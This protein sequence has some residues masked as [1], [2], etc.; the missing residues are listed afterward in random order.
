MKQQQKN[1][2]SNGWHSIKRDLGERQTTGVFF[3][4]ASIFLSK[5]PASART[6]GI[7]PRGH[8][9]IFLHLSDISKGITLQT[10]Q[11]SFGCSSGIAIRTNIDY[12]EISKQY[13]FTYISFQ[14][15]HDGRVVKAYDLKSYSLWDRRF[16]PCSWR[17]LTE[18]LKVTLYQLVTY[19]N[20]SYCWPRSAILFL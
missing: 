9:P 14:W 3:P 8:V 12:Y 11:N 20:H 6:W 4:A 1:W 18:A 16:K 10:D 15:R 19:T 5:Q 7:A 13:I 2:R 17:F